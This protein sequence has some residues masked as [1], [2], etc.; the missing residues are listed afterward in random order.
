MV[1]DCCLLSAGCCLPFVVY[2]LF[3]FVRVALLC[4]CLLVLDVC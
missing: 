3:L 1:V 2:C 4:C